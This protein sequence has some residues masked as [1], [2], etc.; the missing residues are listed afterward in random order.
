MDPKTEPVAKLVDHHFNS[1]P[2]INSFHNTLLQT[3]QMRT[4]QV[5]AVFHNINSKTDA[6]IDFDA[7]N[8][9]DNNGNTMYCT[10]RH[11]RRHLFTHK[12]DWLVQQKLLQKDLPTLLQVTKLKASKIHFLQSRWQHLLRSW[13]DIYDQPRR[14]AARP[15]ICPK[16]TLPGVV[17]LAISHLNRKLSFRNMS[18]GGLLIV[19]ERRVRISSLPQ[20]NLG[21]YNRAI[22]FH[23]TL[24]KACLEDRV[25]GV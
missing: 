6:S 22:V 16:I 5:F 17:Q 3:L 21:T 11:S 4:A 12:I 15:E 25:S 7:F 18:I 2:C 20:S 23:Q 1:N 10:G 8:S 13:C 19:E 9:K 14:W 24:R